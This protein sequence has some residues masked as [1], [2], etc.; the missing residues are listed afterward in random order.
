MKRFILIIGL[1]G[2]PTQ[3]HNEKAI[4]YITILV[5]MTMYSILINWCI[6][7]QVVCKLSTTT[8]MEKVLLN[9]L[10][11]SHILL[12]KYL[13]SISSQQQLYYKNIHFCVPN[14]SFIVLIIYVFLG[15]EL[16]VVTSLPDIY[17]ANLRTSCFSI[18]L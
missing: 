11:S 4:N 10:D 18:L 13:N 5:T 14:A 16:K 1:T 17:S 7:Y 6:E 9:N 8:I 3:S 2:F 12:T 15:V